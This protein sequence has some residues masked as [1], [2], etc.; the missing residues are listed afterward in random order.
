MGTV[1]KL[2]GVPLCGDARRRTPARARSSRGSGPRRS[3]PGPGRNPFFIRGPVA[4][5]GP[6]KGAPYGLAVAVRAKAGPFDLGTVVVRQA[7]YVDPVDAHLTVVSDPLPVILR[8][9]RCGCARCT[10]TSIGPGSRSTRPPARRSRSR[11]TS[12]PASGRPSQRRR[13]ASRP[14]TAPSS[15]F[16]P[17]LKLRLTGKGQTTDGKH[18]GLKATLTQPAHQAGIKSV[19]VALPLSLALDPENAVSDTLCEFEEGQKAD[20]KCPKSSIVGSAKAITPLLNRPLTG[21]V[22]FVKNVRIDKKTG[23]RIRTLPTLLLALR[24]RGRAQRAGDQLGREDKLVSTFTDRPRRA[25]HPVRPH[26]QGRQEGHPGRQRQ[27]L[28]AHQDRHRHPHRPQRQ[29][30]NHPALHQP[31]LPRTL[32]RESAFKDA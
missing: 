28:Q 18:P 21:P 9:C 15:G 6:Y 19:K 30:P 27:R 14:A 1:A 3:V 11:R 31:T 22:Y 20:P 25:G 23:R 12:S 16:T 8:A 7:I 26:P 5:T 32:T 13:A 2:K 29:T 24:G 17:K 10:W 4:L